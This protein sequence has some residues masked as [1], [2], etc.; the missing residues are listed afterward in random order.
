MPDES[1]MT[2][3]TKSGD[4]SQTESNTSASRVG[5]DSEEIR[6]VSDANGNKDEIKLSDESIMMDESKP[7]DQYRTE[8]NASA[9]RDGE[10]SEEVGSDSDAN[11]NKGE[12]KLTND[13]IAL[14]DL[15]LE[16]ENQA[17]GESPTSWDGELPPEVIGHESEDN[18]LNPLQYSDYRLKRKSHSPYDDPRRNETVYIGNLFFDVTAD[19]LRYQMEKYGT[20]ERVVIV[21]DSRGLSK[22]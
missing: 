12:I 10:H 21:L 15:R 9:S 2:K 1:I 8:S 14:D 18:R 17:E 19:D 20:V 11:G 22:G 4:Q 7:E 13:S 16:S 3:E 5:E 6:A